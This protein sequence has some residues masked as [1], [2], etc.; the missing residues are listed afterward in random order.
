[1]GWPFFPRSAEDFPVKHRIYHRSIHWPASFRNLSKVGE[2]PIR[3]TSMAYERANDKLK[4]RIER[5]FTVD[6][7]KINI[8]EGNYLYNKDNE[9][10]PGLYYVTV[11]F[12][13]GL[14][15]R[16]VLNTI[17][18]DKQDRWFLVKKIFYQ[19]LH[20]MNNP[21][22]NHKYYKP[23]LRSKGSSSSVG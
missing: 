20:K 21:I 23:T 14:C 7:S 1:M 5:Q 17:V 18:K 8:I 6:F 9:R 4:E 16:G 2:R 11:C 13:D 19:S 12:E 22:H 15:L 10:L 3:Y